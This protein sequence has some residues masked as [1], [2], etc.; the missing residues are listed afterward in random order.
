MLLIISYAGFL[1][2]GYIEQFFVSLRK[3]EFFNFLNSENL[4]REIK[5]FDR[6]MIATVLYKYSF[7]L[8][9]VL[10][11]FYLCFIKFNLVLWI[12]ILAMAILTI[13]IT[14]S[15]LF[16]GILVRKSSIE[17]LEDVWKKVMNFLF[18][19]PLFPASELVKIIFVLIN[20]ISR[21]E[22]Y[23]FNLDLSEDA[24]KNIIEKR[25]ELEHEEK[26]MLTSIFEFGDTKVSEIMIPRIDIAAV[27][28]SD[29][30]SAVLK[31]IVEQGYSRI[32]VYR[33]NIDE[34]VGIVY[35]KDI[36][37]EFYS[38]GSLPK[39]KESCRSNV[40]FIPESARIDD[41]LRTMR[42]EKFQIAVALD[43]YG[44]TAGLVTLEDIVEE[45][46]GEIEDEYDKKQP[47]IEKQKDGSY[48]TSAHID[49]ENIF[50]KLEL[51]TPELE[52][53][54]SIGGYILNH[55]GRIPV[56]GEKIEIKNISFEILEADQRKIKKIKIKR[57]A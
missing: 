37:K 18:Y 9:F 14:S 8:G 24:I 30:V 33:E 55:L 12:R 45:I 43:E 10:L 47:K 22:N 31:I 5:T 32:P 44:G 1:F 42:N 6:V 4:K 40:Y 20:K 41:L 26:E 27:E 15:Y 38:K 46:F 35:A 29:D 56:A 25:S 39:L 11:I 34:I 36:L 48:I 2:F 54:E 53:V 50:E 13:F 52:G 16:T 3:R 17:K 7:F 19:I 57:K 51:E 23:R 49:I 28:E 21:T